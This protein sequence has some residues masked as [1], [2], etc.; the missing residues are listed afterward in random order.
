MKQVFRAGYGEEAFAS[1]VGVE[2][3]GY[4]YFL[5]RVCT[6][7]MDK[8]MV[9]AAALE[10]GDKREI[11]L[12]A[13]L[14]GLDENLESRIRAG[15][16]S[17][18]GYKQEEIMLV[19]I[20][21]HTGPATNDLVGC[22]KM[23][24]EYVKTVPEKFLTAA[25]RALKDLSEVTKCEEAAKP[26][27]PVGYNRVRPD[28]PHDAVVRGVLLRRGD[29]APLALVSY[30][31]HPVTLGRRSKASADYP[32]MLC[33]MS[34]KQGYKTVFLNGCCGDIDPVSN[35]VKWGSG[36]RTTLRAY[37][38]R[39]WEG[40]LAGLKETKPYLASMRFDASIPLRPMERSELEKLAADA[41]QPKVAEVWLKDMLARLGEPN[42]E[43]FP[44]SGVRIGNTC[45]FAVPYEGFTRIGDAAR[46]TLPGKNLVV[47]GCADWTRTYL[48]DIAPGEELTYAAYS[49]AVLYRHRIIAP[50][51]AASLGVQIGS[52]ARAFYPGKKK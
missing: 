30:P 14:I 38:R 46:E 41:G 2:L 44:V 32:G 8:L 42:E 10:W 51:A 28:G 5:D 52:A 43:H 35:R 4:G 33:R 29:K 19:C 26:I 9:R 1:P 15:L 34:N 7:I 50:G 6:G 25:R 31:C 47:L 37:A 49:A 3:A 16:E 22:G 27:E 24:H 17:E 40:F 13:D 20:H 45:F 39:I 23:D 18:F 21:T 48:P 36:T 12:S 11:I